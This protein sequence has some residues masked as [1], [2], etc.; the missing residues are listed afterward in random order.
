MLLVE[1]DPAVRDAT[2]MLLKVEGYQVTAVDSLEQARRA[3]AA[4]ELDLVLTDYHLGNS[5]TGVQ[6]ISALREIRGAPV[7]SVL[8][9]GDTSAAVHELAPDPNLRVTSKPIN[10]ERLLALLREFLASA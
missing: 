3:G 6:V 7:K 1:D 10:A 4:A 8:I 2:A 9:T 5:E